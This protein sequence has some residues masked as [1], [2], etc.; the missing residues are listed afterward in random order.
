MAEVKAVAAAAYRLAG[1]F[2]V[3]RIRRAAQYLPSTST[4]QTKPID[5]S[6]ITLRSS[7]CSASYLVTAFRDRTEGQDSTSYA[8]GLK[9][10]D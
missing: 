6:H 9:V 5:I 4:S 10:G 2:R 1:L 3:P 8:G 7:D